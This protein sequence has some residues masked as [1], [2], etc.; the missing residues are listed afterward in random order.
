MN[1]KI[2]GLLGHG[3]SIEIIEIFGYSSQGLPGVEVIG[4]GKFSRT[5]K[6]KI[7]FF[8]KLK[9]IKLPLKRYILCLD[10][11]EN[12][13]ERAQYQNLEL[14]FLLLLWHLAGVLPMKRI[15]D[16]LAYGRISSNGKILIPAI[17]EQIKLALNNFGNE[18]EV[19][20]IFGLS[21]AQCVE[22][23]YGGDGEPCQI[24]PLEEII[25]SLASSISTINDD[26][27]RK[28]AH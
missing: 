27:D 22:R 26:L 24:L 7:I 4:P 3:K 20:K 8:T 6:E 17:G 5:L 1:S 11:T 14:P 2:Y 10:L 15:D 9:K 12:S 19:P 16:C 28:S 23:M 18:E 25:P 13:G 21:D